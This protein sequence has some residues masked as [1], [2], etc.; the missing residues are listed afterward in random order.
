MGFDLKSI[1]VFD[2]DLK[3][4]Y[5]RDAQFVKDGSDTILEPVTTVQRE[6]F[7]QVS[8]FLFWVKAIRIAFLGHVR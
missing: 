1:L 5:V 4:V 2:A 6:Q 3:L 8:F 7:R